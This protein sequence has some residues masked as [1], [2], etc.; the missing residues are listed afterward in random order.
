M[1]AAKPLFDYPKYWAECFGPAPFLPMSRE[2]MD[3][4]GWDSCDIIIVTGDAYVD[5]PSFGMAIIGRL[6]EAQGFRVGI[7]SQPDWQSKDDFMKLGEPNLFFGVAA[8]NMDSMINRY[9]ADRKARSDDAYT[10]GGLAGKRPDRASLVYSQRCK[11][12]YRHVPVVLGGIEASLRR[13]GHY[14]YWSDK[15]RRS[16][17]MD[18]TADILLYGNAERAIVEVAQRLARGERVEAIT[19]VRGTAFIRK[20]A[21]EGWFEIDSTRIDRPGKI[22]K[23]I[24]PYVNTQDLSACAIEKDKGPQDDPNEAK[25]VELLPHPKLE[26]DRTVIRLPSFEKV[27]NDPA[28]YAHANR[29]LHLETNPGNA[30]ALVQRHD[31]RELWLNPPP[32]PLTTEEMDYVFAAPYARVPHPA[33]AGAK[34]P[35]YEMIRFS[36]NIMRGCF[37]GCT[38]CSITEHEGRIIQSR[39]HESILH[40]IEEMKNVPGF[41]GVVSDLG[42]PTANM[43]R[44]ACK[45]QEIEKHCRKPSCVFPG[46]CENLN[47][48]HSSL[49]ELYRK[50]RALPGVKKILI[51]SGLRYDLA[52]ESPEYVK[53]LVTHHVG[54]YLKIAPEHTERGPL[55]KMMKPGIGSYDRFKRM[56]EKYSKEAGKEQYLIPY[57]I[58]AHPGTTDEDMMNLA[59]WLKANGFRADQVQAFYPSPMASATAMYHTGKNP[60]RKVTYKSEGVTVV[61]SE[62]QRR[63]H[64]A[65]LRYHDPKGWPLLREAL[66]SMGRA[67]LI[68]NGKHQLIPAHQPAT[69]GYQSARR[70]NSTPVGSKKAGQGGK[71]LT[72][73]NGLPPRSHDGNAWDK[74]EQAKAAAE[75]RRKAEKMGK[76]AG[77]GGKSQRPVAP[78]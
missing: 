62:E 4:L 78:R 58:A 76:P 73:H 67:D 61:K 24:N 46:I 29:V 45:S 75:A 44:L 56:F 41:T 18:A 26:R 69:E 60:L 35:A 51:A 38:F 50:A 9:T 30:R 59:L 63:L 8:G 23:I 10:P 28:L 31:D 53:E 15:V 43:Y 57:F 48:D 47:T 32:I 27:R 66:I 6:L 70:K 49:I 5:H 71:I 42:G 22:D 64:K 12:A 55:D 52:V 68:G 11:E 7:I 39:S 40:E 20:D 37:G 3:Q 36:V 34:I 21:P 16:I 54:G 19:D 77:K 14:D 25:P 33:Y 2:E 65:F 72:Q 17:L 74:R 13:I 1:H